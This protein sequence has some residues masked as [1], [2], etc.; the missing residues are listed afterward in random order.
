MRELSHVIERV[1]LMSESDVVDVDA[2]NLK[3]PAPQD[4]GGAAALAASEALTVEEAEERLVRQA[5]ERTGGNIQRA[6]ALLGLSR[7]S[8]YRRMEKYAIG[9]DG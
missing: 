5:L 4:I 8:L 9:G 1:A 2:L 6:A 7:P 3:A